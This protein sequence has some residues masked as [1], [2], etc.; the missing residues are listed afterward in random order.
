LDQ[1]EFAPTLLNH[2]DGPIYVPENAKIGSKIFKMEL[3]D[4]DLMGYFD[5]NFEI[6][7]ILGNPSAKIDQFRTDYWELFYIDSDGWIRLANELDREIIGEHK[8][9]VNICDG[10][11]FDTNKGG[12][13]IN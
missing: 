6:F 11:A 3:A 4:A 1:N 13:N 8:L 10:N 2:P 9:E 7:Y 5:W 12:R